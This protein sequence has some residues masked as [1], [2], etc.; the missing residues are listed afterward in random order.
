MIEKYEYVN[1][2]T[3]AVGHDISHYNEVI[4]WDTLASMFLYIKSS[5]GYAYTDPKFQEHRKNAILRKIPQ[6]AYHFYDY[7]YPDGTPQAQ[8][9]IRC[10]GDNCGELPPAVDFETQYQSIKRG[11]EWIYKE[12]AK[13]SRSVCYSEIMEMGYALKKKYLVKP[14]L[15][16]GNL[17][18][19]LA[20][21]A[22]MIELFDLWIAQWK[23]VQDGSLYGFPKYSIWQRIGDVVIQGQPGVWDINYMRKED[24]L[25]MTNTIPEIPVP[26]KWYDGLTDHEILIKLAESHSL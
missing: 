17:L 25:A 2:E 15:Y 21:D 8:Q 24:Y 19:W 12:I 16:I 1:G 7:R 18:K 26:A 10:I 14:K 3:M 4:N 23:W 5:Q 20:P 13:P 11:K 6:G 9:M 22:E